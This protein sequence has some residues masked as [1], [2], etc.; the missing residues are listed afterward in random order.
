LSKFSSSLSS[1][2]MPNLTVSPILDLLVEAAAV[3]VKRGVESKGCRFGAGGRA[4]RVMGKA[5]PPCPPFGKGGDAG[6]ASLEWLQHLF[7]GGR[8]HGS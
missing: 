8:G 7:K 2:D 3:Y 5:N 6:A 4:G 1:I